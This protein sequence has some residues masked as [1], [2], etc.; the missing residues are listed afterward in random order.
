MGYLY[1]SSVLMSSILLSFRSLYGNLKIGDKGA[2]GL[3]KSLK[4]NATLTTLE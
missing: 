1:F 2:V 3:G 4:K